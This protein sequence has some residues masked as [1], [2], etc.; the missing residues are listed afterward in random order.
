LSVKPQR[1]S[2]PGA[3]RRCD[4]THTQLH[5]LKRSLLRAALVQTPELGLYRQ[6]C[7]AANRAAEMAWASACPLLVFPCLFDELAWMARQQQKKTPPLP[8]VVATLNEV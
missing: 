5:Q 3:G 1:F 8:W 2:L 7:G 4:R 6:L